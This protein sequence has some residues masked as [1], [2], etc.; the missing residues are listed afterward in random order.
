VAGYYE[1]GFYKRRIISW[2]AERTISHDGLCS[3]ELVGL[4]VS[5]S[6]S[7]LILMTDMNLS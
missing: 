3:M 2:L 5:R 7:Q 6:V 1:H 4:S